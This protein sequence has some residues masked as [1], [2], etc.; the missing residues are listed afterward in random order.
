MV[1]SKFA[2]YNYSGNPT[3]Y[4]FVESVAL[5]AKAPTAEVPKHH[6][7]IVDRSGSMYYDLAAL[8]TTLEKILTLQEYES[9]DI[10]VSLISYSS[11]GDVS[12]HFER[13]SIADVMK[14]GS[15]YVEQIRMMRVTGM[16]CISQ[17][18]EAARRL[19]V[20]D[21]LTCITLHSDGYANDLSPYA[22]ATEINRQV[23]VLK[24]VPNVF[25]NTIAYSNNSDFKLLS[26]IANSLSGKCIST[27]NIKSVYDALNEGF[28][29]LSSKTVASLTAPI[30]SASYQVFYSKSARRVNGSSDDLRISGLKETDD[31][32]IYRYL[33]VSTEDYKAANF[34]TSEPVT[35]LAFA[36]AQLSEGALNKAKYAVVSSRNQTLLSK[37]SRA[38]VSA[39]LAAFAEDLDAALFEVVSHTYSENYG[40]AE[41]SSSSLLELFRILNENTADF[42]VEV[43][44]LAKNYKKR[45]VR[46]IQGSR[47]EDGTLAKPW[48]KTA[49]AKDE[50]FVSSRGFEINRNT[51]TV[52][53]L[54]TRPV[55]LKT[56][57]TD[58]EITEVAGIR[59]DELRSFNNYTVIGDGQ[60]NVSSLPIRISSKKLFRQLAAA[61]FVSG[62][63]S[64]TTT[65]NLSLADVPVVSYGAVF[66]TATLADTFVKIRDLTILGGI[67]SAL[68]KN[69]SDT[70]T[71]EQIAELSK[72]YL[73]SSLNL[74]FPTTNDY[75]SLAEALSS[76][77]VDTRPS[78]KVNIGNKDMLNLSKLHSANKFLERMFTVSTNTEKPTFANY[79]DAG[80]TFGYKQL[81]SRTKITAVDNVMKP[82]FENW[83]GLTDDLRVNGILSD[84]SITLRDRV[85]DVMRSGVRGD[86]AV[87]ILT[88]ANRSIQNQIDSLYE[89]EICPLAFYVGA[90]GLL[91][92]QLS[93][94]ALTAEALTKAYPEVSLA[95]AEQEG[96]FFDVQGDGSVILSVF[97]KNEHFSTGAVE[98]DE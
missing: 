1:A 3:N 73:S 98:A 24:T 65:Y 96:S 11:K 64:P 31:R 71:P 35:L 94:S 16:T 14:P 40:L 67:F 83:L 95:K 53:L 62:E 54:L 17:S 49:Y 13:V 27:A 87:E 32:V 30:E 89:Q 70:Y 68:L 33:E 90:T 72:H 22:E 59:L 86:E 66:S 8:K 44:E 10:R 75:T 7:I 46:R 15:K 25:V 60:V 41:S 77:K 45:G 55:V 79:W 63:L 37:H 28:S 58:T 42:T 82:I 18:L 38:L 50:A 57:D 12:T 21:E 19:I 43:K 26:H 51:A 9:S 5:D 48:L 20:K 78:Y 69:Q 85:D 36:K 29:T 56:V 47:A 2:L 4:Y 88:E 80:V 97:V 84:M 52:N 61:G 34:K 39:D 92:D 93:S 76:G 74:N 81:S 23:D 91:P 6:V